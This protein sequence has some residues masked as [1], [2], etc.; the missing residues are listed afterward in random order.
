M[1]AVA[2]LV[3]LQ[4][5]SLLQLYAVPLSI[6]LKRSQGSQKHAVKRKSKG[7]RIASSVKKILQSRKLHVSQPFIHLLKL[8]D[9]PS[10]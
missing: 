6:F 10:S 3:A 2:L 5:C 1:S 9:N 7:N 4:L 8:I